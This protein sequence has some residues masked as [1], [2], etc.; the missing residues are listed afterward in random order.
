MVVSALRVGKSLL[1]EANAWENICNLLISKLAV[2]CDVLVHHECWCESGGVAAH[3]AAW[4][5]LA[6]AQLHQAELLLVM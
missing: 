1:Q 6:V 4:Q 2:M 3:H 5:L